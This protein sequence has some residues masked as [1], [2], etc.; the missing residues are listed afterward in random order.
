M[1]DYQNERFCDNCQADTKH[2]VH[3]SGHER[4]GQND[5]WTCLVC[6]WWYSGYTGKY[7]PPVVSGD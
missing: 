5:S 1:P 2:D 4:D 6:G 3:E 7:E